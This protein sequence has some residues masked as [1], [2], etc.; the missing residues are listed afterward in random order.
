MKRSVRLLTR[1]MTVGAFAM[2]VSFASAQ[3]TTWVA[4]TDSTGWND[5]VS[6]FDGAP[7]DDG[8]GCPVNEI[9]A[10]EIFADEAYIMTNIA[11][12]GTYTFSACNGTGGTAWDIS[13]TI[14]STSGNVDAFGL[15]DGSNCALT[16]TASES[17]TYLIVVSEEGACGTST[18]AGTNNG[19]PAIT[20]VSSPET[21]CGAIGIEEQAYNSELGL[22]PNPTTG[23][24]T[25][26]L[27]NLTKGS[28]LVEVLDLSGRIVRSMN[29]SH[30]DRLLQVIDM[31]GETSGAYV[32]RATLNDR[33]VT[34]SL[35]LS[36]K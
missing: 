6:T 21:A 33:I 20:C 11:E 16:W 19:F 29:V 24:V 13:Y 30:G 35:M 8:T 22:Y 12:G 14:I 36:S 17:G 32:V 5:F 9:T 26:E 10:F 15:D 2:S 1:L 23:L 3:C 18:N 25:M 34:T 28:S 27:N 4:P 31:T 7:C